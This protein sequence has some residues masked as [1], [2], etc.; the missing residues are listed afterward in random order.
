VAMPVALRPAPVGA[1]S[2]HAFPGSS[3]F[4]FL[5]AVEAVR[6]LESALPTRAGGASNWWRTMSIIFCG[7]RASRRFLSPAVGVPTRTVIG[8]QPGVGFPDEPVPQAIA[9]RPSRAV[10]W[11]A[12]SDG[13]ST[14]QCALLTDWCRPVPVSRA[15]YQLTRKLSFLE[16]IGAGGL[17]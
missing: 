10:A 17:S 11:A 13:Y 4:R 16:A 5:Y 2:G 14:G 3:R 15:L 8:V 9:G 7:L 6:E 1:C 12:D